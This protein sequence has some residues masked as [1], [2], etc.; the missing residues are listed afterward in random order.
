[1]GAGCALCAVGPLN[2]PVSAPGSRAQNHGSLTS[3]LTWGLALI[4]TSFVDY[5]SGN[6]SLEEESGQRVRQ[7][8][9]ILG[10]CLA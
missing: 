6:L 8:F 1:V 10:T 2:W 3:V 4:K 7:L 5:P 9:G